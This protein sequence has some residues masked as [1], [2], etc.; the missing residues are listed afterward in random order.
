MTRERI[1]IA[2]VEFSD[3]E[4]DAATDVLESGYV[5]QGPETEA[6]EREFAA[7]VDAEHAVAVSSGSAALHLVYLAL[8]S[9]GDQVL[10][11]ALSHIS[12]ASMVEFADG[13]PV[14]CDVDP[15]TATLDVDD[16]AD[17]ITSDTTAVVPVH[18]FGNACDVD[19]IRALAEAHD[20][21]VVWDAAQAHA[22]TYEGEDVGSFDDVVTYSFY[23]TKNMT[24]CEGGMVTTNDD[25]LAERI[26]RLR[27]HWQT[28]KY[29]HPDVGLNYRMTDVQAA[30]GRRQ[31][32]KL[33][34]FTARRC[35]NASRMTDGLS[36]LPGVEP[37][38][39][40]ENAR[41]TYHQYTIQVDPDRL[42][43]D[44]RREFM[45]ALDERGI[46]TAV[47]YPRALH[48]QPA[49]VDRYGETDLPAAERLC[50]RVVSLP[51]HPHVTEDDVDRIVDAIEDLT[52]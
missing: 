22:T 36:S 32:A 47:H 7:Y 38:H 45:D 49:F 35:E 19:S 41:H 17:R 44:S 21:D 12:T 14:F 2:K 23:P 6:F 10:V 13:R 28:D 51:V 24:T 5:R 29:Y 37:P 4:I 20:L 39:E 43:V 40:T 31:L 11:P 18:L 34:Q 16:A 9:E 50:D 27:S 48:E 26:R 42:A 3:D 8:L 33:D 52:A 46:D 25:E 15:A 1:P 30:I